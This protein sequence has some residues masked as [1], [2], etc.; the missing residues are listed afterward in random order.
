[1]LCDVSFGGTE[2]GAAL[3]SGGTAD[4]GS[5]LDAG[6]D[7]F[8]EVLDFGEGTGL[9]AALL[10]A[11]GAAAEDLAALRGVFGF[12]G[13]GEDSGAV[14]CIDIEEELDSDAGTNLATSNSRSSLKILEFTGVI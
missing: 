11:L 2:V 8:V 6:A 7:A 12:E 5:T 10:G 9:V 4:E 13:A 1:M 14:G 3:V